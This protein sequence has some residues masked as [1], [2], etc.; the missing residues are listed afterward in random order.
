LIQEGKIVIAF[1]YKRSG[2]NKLKETEIYLPLSLELGWFSS[3]ES[4]QFIDF[5][6][7][8]NLLKKTED[9]FIPTF[10]IDTINIPVGFFPSK[11]SFETSKKELT[12]DIFDKI[13]NRIVIKTNEN[14]QNVIKFI[15]HIQTEK[16]IVPIVAALLLAIEHE[17]EIG[18]LFDLVEKQIF[19]ENE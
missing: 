10:D 9:V 17:V 2:K 11:S 3:K 12:E 16:N 19:K 6:L 1:L 5:A 8:Q 4:R 15:N 14:S 7:K 18:D 13:V